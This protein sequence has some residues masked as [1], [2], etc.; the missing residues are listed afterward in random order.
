MATC[1]AWHHRTGD[2]VESHVP[3]APWR[4]HRPGFFAAAGR[5]VGL[6]RGPWGTENDG[7]VLRPACPCP[8][9]RPPS[10]QMIEDRP[11]VP[12]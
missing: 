3:A 10:A 5:L 12:R 9:D 7:T 4:R 6:A 11:Q 2:L 1:D 8:C